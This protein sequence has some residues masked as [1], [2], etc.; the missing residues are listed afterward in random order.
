MNKSCKQCTWHIIA[1]WQDLKS[2]RTPEIHEVD[3][4]V[5]TCGALLKKETGS[6][7]MVKIMG[8]TKTEAEKSEKSKLQLAKP[9][10][11]ATWS[12]DEDSWEFVSS[13]DLM[14][15]EMEIQEHDM[16]A[17]VTSLRHQDGLQDLL[18]KLNG[19]Q[20]VLQQGGHDAAEAANSYGGVEVSMELLKSS[21]SPQVL[22]K[23]MENLWLL[24]DDHE[25][26]QAM[27][28]L[29]G[30]RRLWQILSRYGSN[31][32]ICR[33]IFMLMAETLYGE[34]RCSEFWTDG[35]DGQLL[36]QILEWSISQ[37]I[38]PSGATS[39]LGFI[40]D[41]TALWLQRSKSEAVK[42]FISIVPSLLQALAKCPEDSLLMQH[43]CR[44]LWA[45]AMKYQEAKMDGKGPG[46]P[47]HLHQATLTA[48]EELSTAQLPA[49]VMHY[50]AMALKA[51]KELS[52]GCSQSATCATAEAKASKV[53]GPNELS[54]ITLDC[55]DWENG[56]DV[57]CWDD[58]LKYIEMHLG[59]PREV[60]MVWHWIFEYEIFLRWVEMIAP[61]PSQAMRWN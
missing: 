45:F 57:E 46:W 7:A 44:L 14:E 22:Q 32:A 35:L 16:Q 43:G 21:T 38:S 50:N 54:V 59:A 30:H 55:M 26:C 34:S 5:A 3:V 27:I 25:S 33:A 53:P 61:T 36:S 11:K 23:T 18:L 2:S 13:T 15:S 42:A 9:L 48:L 51:M 10:G 19:F 60:E 47:E 41:V 52:S 39:T 20:Q 56:E 1:R 8:L 6:R 31:A 58:S 17:L 28:Q 29:N 37:A 49:H 12:V 40:C 4:P 24:V